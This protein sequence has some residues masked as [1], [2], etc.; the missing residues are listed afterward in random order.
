MN[1]KITLDFT[2]SFHTYLSSGCKIC[3]IGAKMVL[4]VTGLCNKNCFYCPISTEK[5][6]KDVVFA[7]EVRVKSDQDIIEE[8][9]SM[10]ALGTGITGGEPLLKLN[11]VLHYINLLK[12]EFGE[13]HH[14]HLYT[15]IAPNKTTLELLSKAGLDEIRFNPPIEATGRRVGWNNINNT[16]FKKSIQIAKQLIPEVGIEIPSIHP[17][18]EII[19][20]IIQMDIFLNLNEL[21]YSD[22]NS[23]QLK[24]KGFKLKN[25]FSN[26]VS[27]SEDIAKEI[28]NTY[29]SLNLKPYPL[30]HF[31]SSRY[32]DAVQLRER[33]KRKAKNFA[34]SFMEITDDGTIIYGTIENNL[35]N[36]NLDKGIKLLHR[37][38]VPE[39]MFLQ[40]P[41]KIEIAGWILEDI[42]E[43]LKK[44]N[45]EVAIVEQYPMKDGLIVER[46]PL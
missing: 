30:I 40:K 44:R 10:D 25:E 24:N 34:K 11:R 41:N 1:K 6:N 17:I 13:K 36:N 37:L 31:C 22:T 3:Q 45:Y 18:P 19:K 39:D 23:L 32:K 16:K 46:I 2:G 8:A 20:L 35:A 21:E 28:I 5:K 26:A 38:G 12:S 27:G 29:R 9:R 42:A 43:E 14:V 33:L 4:F 15:A 7:N